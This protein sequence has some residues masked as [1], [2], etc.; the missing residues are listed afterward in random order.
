VVVAATALWIEA[1][2]A[3]P[4]VNAHPVV[5]VYNE[6]AI[7]RIVPIKYLTFVILPLL[8]FSL[9]TAAQQSVISQSQLASRPTQPSV[10]TNE[11]SAVWAQ[12]LTTV[13][14]ASAVVGQEATKAGVAAYT[15][16][17]QLKAIRDQVQIKLDQFRVA[18]GFPGATIG[19]VLPD[20]RSAAVSTGVSDLAIKRPLVPT[21]LMLAGSIGKTFVA[22]T[23]LQLASEGKVNLDDKIDHWFKTEPWFPK[24]PNATT[25]TVRMLLNH[26]SGIPNHADDE[27]F[28]KAL[29]ANP[30]R[31]WKPEDV[32]AFVLGKKALFAAGKSFLYADT[33]YTLVGMIIERVTGNT[34]YAEVTRRFLKPLKLDHTIPQE[35]R[36]IPG[37]VNGYSS[38]TNLAGPQGA[39]IVDGKFTVNPQAEWAG[40]GFASTAE[41]LA[42]W[43][44]ALYEGGLIKQP[45][46]DQ[47]LAGIDTGEIDKYG[48]GVEIGE[49]RWGKV[50]GHDGLFPGYAS[51]MQYFPQYKTA[52]AIQFNTDREKQIPDVNG[53]LDEVMKIIV[54]EL[55]GKKFDEPKDRKAVAVDPKIYD[56]YAGRYELERGLVLSV[57]RE[58]EHLMVQVKGQAAAEIFPASETEYFSRRIDVQIKFVKNEQGQVTSLIIVQN[59]RNIPAKK[60][61]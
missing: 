1:P 10:V 25:I 50:L 57:R 16:D 24:L 40:G 28:F 27:K 31:T 36:V 21:D 55:T 19:F 32:L 43:A 18:R 23:M 13:A 54:G 47:M 41:D 60:I 49:G 11:P 12:T 58:G 51:A 26:S 8:I 52:V 17:A 48:L 9:I 46:F 2:K 4:R 59:G 3:H 61:K 20:G 56:N 30:D 29:A 45:Y 53:C 37:V 15:S 5:S 38:F 35:G 33:N 14:P 34:L 22:A 39:M 44:K 7:M 6:L 42:R